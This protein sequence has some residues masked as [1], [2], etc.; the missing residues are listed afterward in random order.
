MINKTVSIVAS[1]EKY[2]MRL[3]RDGLTKDH[4]FHNLQHALAV[5]SAALDIGHQ[6]AFS[7]ED[8]EVLELAAL[9]HDVGFV[10]AYE[11]HEQVSK[12]LAREFL[13]EHEYDP[14][15]TKQVLNCIN[16]TIPGKQPENKFE[17]VIK[18]ADLMGLG[19]DNYPVALAALRHEWEVFQNKAFT[20]VEWF[21]LN[22]KFVGSHEYFTEVARN[23]YGEKKEQ[24]RKFLKKTAK[25][26]R[27]EKAKYNTGDGKIKGS[28]S[29]QMMFKTALRN[30]I[31]LSNLADNKANIMLSVNALIVTVAVPMAA[32]Y[33]CDNLILALPVGTLL[34]TCL[35]SMIFATLATRPIKM[36]GSTSLESIKKGASN[37]FF[38]GNFYKMN[39][40]EYQQGMDYVISDEENLDNS[41]QRDLFFLGKSLGRKYNQ[42]RICY[43][44]FMVGV[45]ISVIMFVVIYRLYVMTG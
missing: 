9:F 23:L 30:H 26:E 33:I 37:L 5:R 19:M 13:Q 24:N 15:K 8:M 28:K 35:A 34:V 2:V 36:S 12:R 45:I 17:E 32:S 31:D 18:D 20:D 39:F 38:F 44:L 14:A 1:A 10:E 11:G 40:D 4:I 25:K 41:I 3:L 6:L 29:A 22:D 27:K 21:E 7:E 43:N 16:A 42:L